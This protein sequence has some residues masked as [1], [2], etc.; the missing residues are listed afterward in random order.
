MEMPIYKDIAIRIP[1][2][3]KRIIAITDIPRKTN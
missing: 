3:L 1:G 2:I